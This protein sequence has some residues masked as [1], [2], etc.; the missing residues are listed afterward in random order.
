MHV[1][2]VWR[3]SFTGEN[4]QESLENSFSRRKLSLIY[5]T[6][7]TTPINVASEGR[8]RV[9]PPCRAGYCSTGFTSLLAALIVE[10]G[11]AVNSGPSIELNQRAGNTQT[12]PPDMLTTYE[13]NSCL[14]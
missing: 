3:V 1:I 11:T 4:F 2:H 8:R 6:Q 10:T 5:G 13:Q 7:F 14:C 12:M 9:L